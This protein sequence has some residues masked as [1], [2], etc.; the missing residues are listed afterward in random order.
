MKIEQKKYSKAIRWQ[1]LNNNSFKAASCNLLPAFGS[2]SIFKDAVIYNNIRKSYPKAGIISNSTS[3]ENYEVIRAMYAANTANTGS[4][5]YGEKSPSFDFLKCELHNQ[6]MSIITLS[7]NE[8]MYA[9]VNTLINAA[10]IE[11]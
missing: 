8:S 2:S 3:G 7:E 1:T 5:F 6:R 4:Y 10:A 9:A 11:K